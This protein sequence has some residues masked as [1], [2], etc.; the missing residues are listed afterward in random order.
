MDGHNTAHGLS[1][2]HAHWLEEK[3]QIPCEL[4]AE[5]GIVSKGVNLVFEYRRNGALLWKQERIEQQDG[6]T[7]RCWAPDGRTTLKQAGIALS[8]WNEDDLLAT[9]TPEAP[10]IIT[11]GQ[12]DTASFKE[13]GFQHVGSV[14]NGATDRPG[15]EEEI[16]PEEDHQFTY[17]WELR[18]ERW[19]PRGGLATAK[20]IILATDGDKAGLVLRDELAVRLGRNRCW[21][22]TYPEG[23]KDANEVRCK[24]GIEA[25]RDLVTNAK[26]MVASRLGSFANIPADKVPGVSAGW[27]DFDRHFKVCPP[28]VIVVTGRANDGKSQWTLA[29]GANLARI[30]GWKGAILQFED[31]PERNRDDLV[32]YAK[33]WARDLRSGIDNAEAWVNRMFVTI[34]PREDLEEDYTLKWLETVVAEAAQRHNCKWVIIDPWNEIEHAWGKQDTEA[35]YLNRALRH[36]KMLARLYRIAIFI[37]VHPTKEILNVKS[38]DHFDGYHI[39]GGAVW[40]NKADL[41]VIVWADN[42]ADT[43]R[44]I[45]VD[46]SKDFGRMG[47]PGTVTMRFVPDRATYVIEH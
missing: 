36:L 19:Y 12:F 47:K 33:S 28:Q 27:P 4:A 35:T 38:V 5:L 42:R 31:N 16:H 30:H 40:R 46:K 11:E 39:N 23:C 13:A 32:T 7:F 24:F 18:G 2:A 45:K 25:V 1:E 6:K 34:P 17:L 44:Q 41:L 9:S 37:V 8:F 21:Y 22:I 15:A 20:K 43:A 10:R 26:P 29:V 3:R 14:P